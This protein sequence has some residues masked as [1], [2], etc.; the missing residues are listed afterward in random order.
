MDR[1]IWQCTECECLNY[2]N[3]NDIEVSCDECGKTFDLSKVIW[4]L[5][6]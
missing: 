2:G 1:I 4:S 5:K 6:K 3:S